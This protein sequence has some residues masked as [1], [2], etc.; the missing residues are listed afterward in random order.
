MKAI[1]IVWGRELELSR[2]YADSIGAKI[3]QVYF[4]GLAKY[5]ILVPFRYGL[6]AIL[7][8]YYLLKESPRVVIVQ[9]P[10]V[11]AV[12]AVYIYCRLFRRL[13]SLDSHSAAFLDR[14]WKIWQPLFKFLSRRAVLNTCHNYRNLE[15]LKRWGVNS[16]VLEF[17]NPCYN[18]IN[19][20]SKK[21]LLAKTRVRKLKVLMVN[22]FADDDEV[23]LVLETAELMPEAIF[24][25]TGDMK[26]RAAKKIIFKAAPNV[27]FTGYLSHSD[28]IAL[29][30][31]CEVV[32]SLTRRSDTVLWSVR[33]A[34]AL[35]RPF[36]AS[37]TEVLRHYYGSLGSFTK[38]SP[39][40]LK[41]AILYAMEMKEKFKKQASIFLAVDNERREQKIK[42]IKNTLGLE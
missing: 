30:Q 36:V 33:E 38:P 27:I 3:I 42:L 20:L 34:I 11:F 8:W 6:Q 12:L 28:F 21:N 41:M 9:N 13:F 32:L 19:C 29:M 10:P 39:I 22:R 15:V 26:L 7:S 4:F 37:D 18:N 25:I 35:G 17:K 2:Q 1:L 5:K 40:N 23:E 31:E 24:F 14:K 16:Q